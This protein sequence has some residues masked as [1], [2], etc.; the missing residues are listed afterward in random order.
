MTIVYKC[1]VM[2]R[3]VRCCIEVYGGI[4]FMVL[5]MGVWCC[6]EVY[7]DEKRYMGM[8]R[9]AWYYTWVLTWVYGDV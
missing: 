1:M 4:W 9:G 8:Y 6:I 3:G 7:G 2:N 5:Y